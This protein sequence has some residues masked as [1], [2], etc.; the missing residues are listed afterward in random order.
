MAG[1]A[2]SHGELAG[3]LA[4]GA[5]VLTGLVT[6]G[7]RRPG[8]LDVAEEHSGPVA[9]LVPCVLGRARIVCRTWGRSFLLGMCHGLS[10]CVFNVNTPSEESPV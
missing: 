9:A 10:V 5:W 1:L 7:G 2:G 3:V 6:V 8:C 4:R